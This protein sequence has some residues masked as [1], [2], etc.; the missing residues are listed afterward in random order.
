MNPFKQD[1]IVILIGA[2]ASVQAKMPDS[3]TM[4]RKV[5][6]LIENDGNWSKF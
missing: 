5:E 1:E 4:I 3:S 6:D 2:G